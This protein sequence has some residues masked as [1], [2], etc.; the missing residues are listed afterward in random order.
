MLDD[1]SSQT[2]FVASID[3]SPDLLFIRHSDGAS[4]PA[5][6]ASKFYMDRR[7]IPSS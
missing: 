1:A 3:T 6:D 2:I 7:R 5:C 4:A